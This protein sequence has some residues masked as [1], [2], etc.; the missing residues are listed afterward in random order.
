MNETPARAPAAS[1]ASLVST[2]A[3]LLESPGVLTQ[4]DIASLR[5]MDP[6]QPEAAFFKLEGLFLDDQMPGEAAARAEAE[7]RWAAVVVGLAHLG[8][9]HRPAARLGHALASAGYSEIR[10]VRLVRADF[11]QLPDELP[12]LARFL[13]ATGIEAD[14]SAAADLV[15]S[16]GT[17]RE[18][19]V[20]RHL[21]RDYYGLVARND[22]D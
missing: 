1:I 6:R 8:A 4:G 12:S 7:T 19:E 21:A 10:F 22:N 16:V 2:I 11:A 15:L 9:L 14:W 18:A 20:R 5:R 17:P 3:R 13:R